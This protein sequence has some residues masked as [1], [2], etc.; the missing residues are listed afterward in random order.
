MFLRAIV[1]ESDTTQNQVDRL[2]TGPAVWVLSPQLERSAEASK[3]GLE[4]VRLAHAQTQ[5]VT[6]LLPYSQNHP[7]VLRRSRLTLLL[8]NDPVPGDWNRCPFS[9]AH[10]LELPTGHRRSFI[11]GRG[12]WLRLQEE[13]GAGQQQAAETG[14]IPEDSP[15]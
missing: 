11:L 6:S 7:S 5:T 15:E 1:I 9:P 14:R 8:R 12:C 10:I 3:S 4:S 13:G 2:S